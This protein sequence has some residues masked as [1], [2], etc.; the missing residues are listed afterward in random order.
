MKDIGFAIRLKDAGHKQALRVVPI[1]SERAERW[2]RELS[3]GTR[4]T[5]ED[6]TDAIGKPRK[7]TETNRNNA[8]GAK[9]NSLAKRGLIKGHGYVTALNPESH[10]RNIR[11]WERV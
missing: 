7:V 4:F 2:V 3:S 6:L 9:I 5:S 10:G 1:W 11:V 8:V